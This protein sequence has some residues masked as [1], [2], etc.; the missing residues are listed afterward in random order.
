MVAVLEGHNG[1]LGV[2]ART[3]T[4]AGAL[5]LTLAVNGVHGRYFNPKDLLDG[6]LNLQF[7]GVGGNLEGNFTFVDLAVALFG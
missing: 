2:F 4:E 3:P 1:T 6:L 7:V 5:A